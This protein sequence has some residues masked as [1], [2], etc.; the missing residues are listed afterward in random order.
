MM[1]K[2]L[3][4]VAFTAL[5]LGCGD[6]RPRLRVVTEGKSFDRASV[7]STSISPVAFVP[8]TVTNDGNQTAFLPTCGSRI[9]PVVEQMV[10]GHWDSYASG[11]C[12][13]SSV[14]VPLELGAGQSHDDEV[15]IGA[16]GHF[17]I[18]M[19]Y[20]SDAQL[21]KHFDAVSWQFDVH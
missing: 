7:P 1:L 18:R 21:S 13:L 19:P 5:T 20:S 14:M 15:A 10:N 8:F 9:A 4:I 16:P 11:F 12:I 2:R 6:D 3:S 17:R